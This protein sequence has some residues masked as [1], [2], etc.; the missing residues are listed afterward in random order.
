LC[1]AGKEGANPIRSYLQHNA[2]QPRE[3]KVPLRQKVLQQLARTVWVR[4]VGYLVPQPLELV[5]DNVRDRIRRVPHNTVSEAWARAKTKQ[6][7]SIL[8]EFG[9]ILE[10]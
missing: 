5:A 10:Q 9:G 3:E 1:T 8:V 7:H 2:T 4:E 6:F